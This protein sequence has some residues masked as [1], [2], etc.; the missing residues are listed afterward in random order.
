MIFRIREVPF[1]IK[2]RHKP[3]SYEE[4]DGDFSKRDLENL[5]QHFKREL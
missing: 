1:G 5:L 4:V 3:F 2:Q